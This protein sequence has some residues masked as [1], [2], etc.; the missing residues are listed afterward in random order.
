MPTK[1]KE[2]KKMNNKNYN[3][4]EFGT[5]VKAIR[6]ENGMTQEEL[7]DKLFVSVDT[8]SRIE[9]GK[10]MCMPE[11]L[12]HICEIFSVSSDFFFGKEYVQ[13]RL[14]KRAGICEVITLL[15]ECSDEDLDRVKQMIALF[16]KK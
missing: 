5:R 16:L 1:R 13:S 4:K 7:A 15:D 14:S 10:I 8:V 3:S 9:N 2:E 6:K 11:H 12:V